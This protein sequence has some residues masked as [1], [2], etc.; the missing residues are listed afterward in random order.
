M[1]I[2]YVASPYAGD[3]KKN[4]KF[5]INACRFVVKQGLA[6]FCPHLLYPNIL[7]EHDPMQRQLGMEMG[8]AMMKNCDELWC[9]GEQ[10]SY[11][12]MAEIEEAQNLSLPIRRV[13]QQ[14]QG[15]LVGEV[16]NT[17]P[18]MEMGTL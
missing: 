1:K 3:I 11:G 2:I 18:R 7:N 13:M 17:A 15:F 16:K 8:I 9:F 12:M 14:E 6:F 4:T 10:I 5:A